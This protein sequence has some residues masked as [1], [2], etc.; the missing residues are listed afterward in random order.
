MDELAPLFR[1]EAVCA[2]TGWNGGLLRTRRTRNGLFPD[3]KQAGGTA[4]WTKFSFVDLC[5]ARTVAKLDNMGFGADDAV[6][7]SK[8]IRIAYSV[9]AKG[10]DYASI[11]VIRSSLPRLGQPHSIQ[12]CD[13]H[14]SIATLLADNSDL[15]IATV[16][17]CSEISRSVRQML[18]DGGFYQ[19]QD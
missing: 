18:F 16:L 1:A 17:D 9:R 12:F 5:Q 10:G 13:P 7:I 15:E 2:V 3:T 6:E 19:D 4:K 14:N 11:A 8:H